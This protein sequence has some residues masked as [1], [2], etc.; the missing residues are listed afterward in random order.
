MRIP[1]G[2]S[3][4]KGRQPNPSTRGPVL[5][6]FL[7]FWHDIFAAPWHGHVQ[8]CGGRSLAQPDEATWNPGMNLCCWK[9]LSKARA[10]GPRDGAKGLIDVLLSDRTCNM[11]QH[12]RYA[13][14]AKTESEDVSCGAPS[15]SCLVAGPTWSSRFFEQIRNFQSIFSIKVLVSYNFVPLSALSYSILVL[16]SLMVGDAY[17]TDEIQ[18]M[19]A[20]AIVC[21]RLT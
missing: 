9:D 12:L 3:D 7:P 14:H 16:A 13:S 2:Y 17:E 20:Y 18:S 11:Q 19:L 4:I 6:C 5:D 15:A 8:S 10:I 1:T 21:L